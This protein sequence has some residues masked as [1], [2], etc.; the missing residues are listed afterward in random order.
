MHEFEVW[1]ERVRHVLEEEGGG[2]YEVECYSVWTIR[3]QN[4][5]VQLPNYMISRPCMNV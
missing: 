1:E 3:I 2:V 4:V 5:S